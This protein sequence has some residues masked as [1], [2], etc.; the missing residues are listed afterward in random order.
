LTPFSKEIASIL[1][2]P[3]ASDDVEIKPDGALYLPEI[4]YR[5][6]LNAAFGPGGW[7]MRP[8]GLKGVVDDR[9]YLSR[10]YQLLA[11]GRFVAEAVGEQQVHAHASLATAEEGA[12]SNALMR[13]CKDLGIASELWDPQYVRDWRAVHAVGVWCVGV[14][15][16]ERKKLWRKV[17]GEPFVYPWKEQE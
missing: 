2:R 14:R 12:K 7:A 15:S 4:K 16:G 11:L 5:R 9:R 1:L 13:C 8:I 10:S 3:V 6:V 17:G